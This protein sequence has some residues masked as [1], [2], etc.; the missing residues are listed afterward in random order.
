MGNLTITT[1]A[2]S[3]AA[4]KVQG[5]IDITNTDTSSVTGIISDGATS[6]ILTKAGSGKLTLSGNN[7]YTGAVTV[8]AG[9]LHIT[10]ANGLGTTDAATTV[11]DGASLSS[12][13]IITFSRSTLLLMVLEISSNGALQ[14]N[15]DDN[16]LTGINNFGADAI[17][18]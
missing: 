13:M 1:G 12:L 4:I 16:T 17:N 9:R 5:T 7:T 6:S 10:H 8:N 3:A 15:A 18:S 11:T 14:F 2:I